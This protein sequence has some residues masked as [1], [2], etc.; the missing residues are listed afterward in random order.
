MRVDVKLEGLNGVLETLKQLP[1]E[2]VESMQTSSEMGVY[3]II[4]TITNKI[5]I[6]STIRN[7]RK[8]FNHH[9]SDLNK[10]VHHSR[11]LQRSWD[12]HGGQGFLF[13][14][15]EVVGDK[16]DVLT[17]EQHYLDL[18]RPE[19]NSAPIAG[20]AIG[21][22]RTAETRGKMSKAQR[23]LVTRPGY[24]DMR[25][26]KL[27]ESLATKESKDKRSAIQSQPH[28]VKLRSQ[29]SKKMWGQPGFKEA[30][31]LAM[32]KAN[33]SPEVKARKSAISKQRNI[34]ASPVTKDMAL[35][36]YDSLLQGVK[37]QALAAKY[38]LGA[39]TISRIK[40]KKH[41]ALS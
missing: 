23:E 26:Q 35:A 30:N 18:W 2:I 36:I 33:A 39:T 7:F 16:N 21:V 10:G 12:K 29:C 25:A 14:I 24:L 15:L 20:S 40:A 19:Y 38:G 5:Y 31:I 3:A 17:R 6:G 37:G 8:R 9:K 13:V 28:L 34:A 41:W 11:H 4:N 22:K 27:R 1:A 32:K